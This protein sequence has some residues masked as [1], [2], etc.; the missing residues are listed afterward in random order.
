LNMLKFV[1]LCSIFEH[2]CASAAHAPSLHA[3]ND[4]DTNA[5]S[6]MIYIGTF[7]PHPAHPSFLLPLQHLV[8]LSLLSTS[9]ILVPSDA[10][11]YARIS[12]VVSWNALSK[13]SQQARSIFYCMLLAN[14]IALVLEL[15]MRSGRTCQYVLYLPWRARANDPFRSRMECSMSNKFVDGPI[16]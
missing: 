8:L 16:H 14:R 2:P 7:Y 12:D 1:R 9:T 10:W 4:V 13:G 15:R 6:I 11:L 5:R 3:C